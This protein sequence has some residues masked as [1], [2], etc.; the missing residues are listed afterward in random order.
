MFDAPLSPADDLLSATTMFIAS[1]VEEYADLAQTTSAMVPMEDPTRELAFVGH[2]WI[3]DTG[4]FCENKVLPHT[5]QVEKPHLQKTEH[6]LYAQRVLAGGERTIGDDQIGAVAPNQIALEWHAGLESGV[7]QRS[8]L[9]EVYLPKPV[10]GD[11]VDLQRDP[12]PFY[13]ESTLTRMIFSEWDALFNDLKETSALSVTVLDRFIA[14]LKIALG[15]PA[16]REDVRAQAREALYREI[17]RYV[18]RNLGDPDLTASS[19]LRDFGVSRAGL[20]RMFEPQGGVRHY[21]TERRAIRAVLELSKGVQTRGAVQAV[22]DRWGFSTGPNFNRVIK[23]MFGASP[24]ALFKA[25]PSPRVVPRGDPD[26]LS[27]Y[28]AATAAG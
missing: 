15:T 3:V 27:N 14:C 17:C 21:I 1:D 11:G 13:A 2:E 20:Y 23:R 6:L 28:L 22:A 4:Y 25:V 7:V 19:I 9:Q 5:Y 18:E 26:L 24:G 12:P 8:H 10:F 16:Q